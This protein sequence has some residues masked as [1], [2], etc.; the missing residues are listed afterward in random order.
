ML[1]VTCGE[2]F[3]RSLAQDL[4]NLGG[5]ILRVTPEGEVPGDNPFDGSPVYSYG[6]R[7]PQGLDWHPSDGRLFASEHGPSGEMGLRAHDEINI[8]IAG[9]NYG[10][11]EVVGAPG[12]GRYIDPIV[13][14]KNTTPPG[15]IEFY[16]GGLLPELRGDLFVATLRS[17]AL[18]RI[19]LAPGGSGPADARVTR[20]ERWFAHNERDGVYGRLR[21]VVEGP[22]GALYVLTSNRDGRGSPR[23][24]DDRILR[25]TPR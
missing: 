11:P 4:D 13:V 2:T 7:N 9:G 1:Y 6:N 12:G 19:G 10:W 22:E 21:D 23:G 5:K 20:I 25:I 3:Q 17:R 16:D 24:G 15:G 8:V 18:I 14:W